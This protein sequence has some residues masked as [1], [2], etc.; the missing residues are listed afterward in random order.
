MTLIIMMILA[1]HATLMGADD[2]EK[3][4]KID[5]SIISKDGNYRFVLNIHV[6][7]PYKWNSEYP[8]RLTLDR[9][10]HISL[11]KTRFTSEDITISEDGKRAFLE[12]GTTDDLN[13]FA[14]GKMNFSICDKSKCKIFKD[15]QVTWEKH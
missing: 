3:D 8:F 10:G 6:F 1:F 15:I 2:K 13:G 14:V 11:K 4:Y 5:T 7:E 12:I 9:Y